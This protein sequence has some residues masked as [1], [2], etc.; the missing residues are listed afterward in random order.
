MS[1][2]KTPIFLTHIGAIPTVKDKQPYKQN[3]NNKLE[4]V[5]FPRRRKQ[6]PQKNPIKI[7]HT[8]RTKMHE[9]LG[10]MKNNEQ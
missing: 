10:K 4:H 3:R 7:I 8:P 2:A 9:I 1:T 5:Q 6:M